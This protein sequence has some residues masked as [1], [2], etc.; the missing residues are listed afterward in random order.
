MKNHKLF[1]KFLLL[2]IAVFLSACGGSHIL[3]GQAR[4]PISIAQVKIYTTPPNNFEEIAIVEGSS[5]GTFATTNQQKTNQALEFIKEE[6]AKLGANGVLLTGYG[7]ISSGSGVVVTPTNST[8]GALVIG[9]HVSL[10]GK[11]IYV[12]P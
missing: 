10:Q 12:K 11:A 2:L 4:T 8:V 5:K 1:S 3:I 6:A 9:S 7:E